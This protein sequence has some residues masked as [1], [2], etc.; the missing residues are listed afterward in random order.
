LG[1]RLIAVVVNKRSGKGRAKALLPKLQ[2]LSA[3]YENLHLIAENSEAQTKAKLRSI[4][5][6]SSSEKDFVVG[7]GGD[8]LVN[9]CIQEIMKR[10]N[11]KC[12][13]LVYPSGTGNDF[14]NCNS[15]KKFRPEQIIDFDKNQLPH[16]VID[17]GIVSD[18]A[19]HSRYFSQVLSTG[20]DSLVNARA[21]KFRFIRGRI[22]YTIATL[23][24]L[25]RF[26]PIKY[27]IKIDKNE[28]FTDAMLV[29]VANGRNYGGGMQIVPQAK[30]DDGL[31]DLII[32]KPVSKLELLRVFPKVFKGGH[33]NHPKVSFYRG[34]NISISTL[35]GGNSDQHIAYADGEYFFPLPIKIS[36]AERS[37][38]VLQP[39]F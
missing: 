10:S 27:Q 5:E 3:N 20:F 29:S 23:L 1:Y 39:N 6:S 33:V 24:V 4:P 16:K 17:L 26:K 2:Y 8:G 13:L 19:G 21:N 15:Q 22:K 30:N 7:I 9:L 36:V 18:D 32:L 35:K 14:A 37:L 28:V 12:K 34:K 25:M 31:L 11:E 38:T